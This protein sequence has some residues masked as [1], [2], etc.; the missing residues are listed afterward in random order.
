MY[1]HLRHCGQ[2][3]RIRSYSGPC[4]PVFKLNTER[5][6]VSHRVS[7]RIQAKWEKIRT[8]ITPNTDTFQALIVAS[9][10]LGENIDFKSINSIHAEFF[11]GSQRQGGM[12][13]KSTEPLCQICCVGA[14]DM[15]FRQKVPWYVK[16]WEMLK[17]CA[18]HIRFC[19]SQY[20]FD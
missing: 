13:K 5:Y 15:K 14:R 8:R 18:S 6:S 12:A 4:F 2:S 7:L 10:L 16:A 20:F 9:H 1:S 19:W 11:R 17:L 3:A